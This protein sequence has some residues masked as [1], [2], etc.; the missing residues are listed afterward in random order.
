MKK[1]LG[2]A[3]LMIVFATP[4]FASGHRHHHHHHH[5]Q[6]PASHQVQHH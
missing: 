3:L 5:S 1:I 2:A 4:V 6:H